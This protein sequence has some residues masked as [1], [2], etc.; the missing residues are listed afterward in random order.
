[1][2]IA[3]KMEREMKRVM[4]ESL[5]DDEL[6]LEEKVQEHSTLV[7]NKEQM[8]ADMEIK[9][10]LI[11]NFMVFMEAEENNDL[12][13]AQMFDEKAMMDAVV[14]MIDTQGNHGGVS[15]AKGNKD[16]IEMGQ[17][18]NEESIM[19][20]VEAVMGAQAIEGTNGDCGEFSNA[21]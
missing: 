5:W 17:I 11:D 9:E 8:L 3:V 21:A 6:A 4:E 2:E 19:V 18:P 16:Q 13:K 14:T 1:M 20:I 15:D 7:A 10:K 12:Q